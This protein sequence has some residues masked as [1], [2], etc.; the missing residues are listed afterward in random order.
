VNCISKIMPAE[1]ELV[2]LEQKVEV[3]QEEIC[4]AGVDKST[5]WVSQMVVIENKSADL[6]IRL[7]P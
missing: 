4:I 2:A 1:R 7:Y 6:R 5:D 3:K